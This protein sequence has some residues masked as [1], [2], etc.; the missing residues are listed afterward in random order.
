MR[1][2]PQNER[3]VPVEALSIE[4][5]WW[6]ALPQVSAREL[7]ANDPVEIQKN[8]TVHE[9]ADPGPMRQLVTHRCVTFGPKSAGFVPEI[10]WF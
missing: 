7:L 8:R 2:D 3:L 5:P 4:L 6:P 10:R 9:I 1:P